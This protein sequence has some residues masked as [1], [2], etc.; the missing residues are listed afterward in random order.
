MNNNICPK[1]VG[2]NINGV[3]VLSTINLR[4]YFLLIIFEINSKSVTS[5]RG[6]AYCLRIN[7]FCFICN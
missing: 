3:K 7:N 4:L 2:E 1:F 5:K 6:L